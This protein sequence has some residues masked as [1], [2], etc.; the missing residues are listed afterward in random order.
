[1]FGALFAIANVRE[2]GSVGRG[3][4][5]SGVSENAVAVADRTLQH[6]AGLLRVAAG[7]MAPE[8]DRITALTVCESMARQ[9]EQVQIEVVAGLVRDGVFAAR[10]YRSP[11]Q[12]VADLLGCDTIVARRR[13]RVAEDVCPR[14]SL[15]GQVLPA[16]LPATAIEFA[17]GRIGL[18]HVEVI[19]EALRSPAARRLTPEAWAAAESQLAEQATVYRPN[20]LGAFAHELISLLDQDGPGEPEDDPPQ[21]NEL[22]LSIRT[23]KVKGQLDGLTRELL[24]TALD[25]LCMPRGPEDE[26]SAAHRRA[27]ALGEICQRVLDTGQLPQGGGERPHLSVIIPLQELEQRARAASLDFGT[28][29]RP[30]D[31]RT[32]ACD[33]RVV[34]VVLG[35]AGQP[36]DVGRARRTIPDAL[37]RAIA[38]RDRGCAKPGCGRPASW[39]EIHHVKA[40]EN[41]G[42]TTVDNCVMLCR[43]HH[44]LLHRESGWVVRIVNGIP[45]FIP[46]KWIDQ[47]QTARRKPPH[48]ATIHA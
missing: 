16:R 14:T 37:R 43:Y 15:D 7:S 44:R 24:A 29:L 2:P 12:A 28:H 27:D 42:E 32:L 21:P 19:A 33:A 39:S 34:P 10:G 30:A 1:M 5:N 20:E 48:L 3:R 9:L 23:G 35:G 36:L 4:D 31:L 41:G 40:W 25:A 47:T 38:A 18:R 6:G 13:V 17:A 26:R 22:H 8:A 46:P 45:E 11:T